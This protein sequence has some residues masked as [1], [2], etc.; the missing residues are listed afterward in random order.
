MSLPVPDP[1]CPHVEAVARAFWGDPNPALSDKN[2][3]RWG[4]QGSRAVDLTKGAWYDHE[5]MEGGGVLDLVTRETRAEGAAA[6][7][8]LRDQ[9]GIAIDPPLAVVPQRQIAATYDYT[10]EEGGLIFQVVRF[11]PKDFRQRRPDPQGRDGWNWS[12]KGVRQVPYRLPEVLE[13][14]A[15]SGTVFVVEGE[16]DADALWKLGVPA[17][18]NAGGAGKWPVEFAAL[19]R[20]AHIIII[21]D[22]D[23]AGRNH[24]A[25]VGASLQ[26]A[27]TSVAILTLAGL[28]PKGDVT[29]WLKSGGSAQQLWALA[30]TAAPWRPGPPESRF[31]AILWS[32][33]D[34]IHQ[35]REWL[36]E[37]MLY[38]GDFALSYGASQSGKSFLAL[39][40]AMAIARGLPFLG[41]KTRKG[42][43]VYQAG[44]GGLGLI[45]R[46][47]AYRQYHEAWE[48]DLP[49]AL[50]P[51]RVDLFA[52]GGE[53]DAFVQEMVS[54]RAYM[55]PPLSLVI[56]DTFATA[57]PG[58]NENASEDMGRVLFNVQR[59]QEAAGAAVLLVHHK[60]AAGERPRGHTSLYANAD[61]ALEV[62]REEYNPRERT[63]RVAKVKDGQDGEKIPFRL[64]SVTIGQHDD[65]KPMT[66]CVVVQP[67]IDT[68]PREAR[69]ETP[70][71]DKFFLAALRQVIAEKAQYA[72]E[73]ITVP[74]PY[75]R[76]AD[77]KEFCLR[78]RRMCDPQDMDEAIRKR[79]TRSAERLIVKDHIGRQDGWLWI[80]E[81]GERA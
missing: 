46:M 79:I 42:S 49:V 68:K 54:W 43:V 1:F 8:Y 59:I 6:V 30:D 47:R 50:L 40:M 17:T 66:S 80:T 11:D 58:C 65:D 73:G 77:W 36:V 29:D 70:P 62:V 19:L 63:L 60:N 27:A 15:N 75:T 35:K 48:K 25:T 14:V 53:A 56:I 37:D 45:S 38:C 72:P 67:D 26:G 74:S 44:E 20:G 10:D 55:D 13:V 28:S 52:P 81:R 31:G 22:N 34:D 71:T 39:D 64:Q 51:T 18:C 7:A 32:G 16:K 2:E 78:Y 24:A 23:E 41:K 33:L 76:V 3:L 9:L 4:H 57:S 12:V 69:I 21:P 61:T 5:L